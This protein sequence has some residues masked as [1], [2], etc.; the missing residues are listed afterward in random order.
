MTIPDEL[1][2]RPVSVDLVLTYEGDPAA[3]EPRQLTADFSA[4][5]LKLKQEQEG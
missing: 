5:L 3:V 2:P 1:R 4:A